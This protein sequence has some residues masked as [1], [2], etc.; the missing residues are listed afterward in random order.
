MTGTAL[1]IEKLNKSYGDHH[2]L[3]DMSFSVQP[4][5]IYGFVGSNGAGK[6]T[7]MRIA[8]GVLAADSGEVRL[9]STPMNDDLRRRIGYMPEERGLYNKEKIADQ[10]SFF[11][12][13]HGMD[14]SAAATAAQDLLERLDLGER[15]QDKLEEL[16]LGNQQ[17]VQLAASLIHDPDVLI[18]DEPFSGLDPVAV[19]VMSDMLVERAQRGVPVLFSSHQLDLVQRLCDRVGIITA[20]QMQAEGGVQELRERGPVVF[21]VGTPARDWYPEF[22]TV[23]GE[24]DGTVLLEVDRQD[25]DQELLRDAL[26]A[27]PVHNFQR[28]IPDLTDLFQEVIQGAKQQATEESTNRAG[29]TA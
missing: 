11:G 18:L 8:L 21:E 12:R 23:V 3:K 29:G 10:L 20:G 22:A 1:H 9:G 17:R 16:S 25:R 5:E 6:S 4:G 13:L 15:A 27:G 26:A 7:T 24:D 28:R 2:V 19:Q 14:K